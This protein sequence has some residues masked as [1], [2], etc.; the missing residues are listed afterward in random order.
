MGDVEAQQ[1]PGGRLPAP[2]KLQAAA[3]AGILPVSP[4]NPVHRSL[5]LLPARAPATRS[6]MVQRGVSSEGSRRRC[7]PVFILT[8]AERTRPGRRGSGAACPLPA[9]PPSSSAEPG[10]SP[11][12][13]GCQHGPSTLQ[14]TQ[15]TGAVSTPL[16]GTKV[17]PSKYQ[18][19]PAVLTQ[20]ID[21][22]ALQEH[23][24]KKVSV[25]I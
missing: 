20:G 14:D 25:E 8:C 6:H 9:S 5:H 3:D 4:A 10:E 21:A 22:F 23:V 16:G 15:H 17:P 18:Q 2:T 1:L 24:G 12:A 19:S 13:S 11:R 7:V